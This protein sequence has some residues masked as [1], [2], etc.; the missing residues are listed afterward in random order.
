[1]RIGITYFWVIPQIIHS[2]CMP[3]KIPF[4]DLILDI[5]KY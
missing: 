1:M 4:K 3:C 5:N 2:M